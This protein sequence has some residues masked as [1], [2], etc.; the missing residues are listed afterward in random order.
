MQS[1]VMTEFARMTK[2]GAKK[3]EGPALRHVIDQWETRL[4]K[5]IACQGDYIEK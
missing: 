3:G 2:E 1:A 5:V 4:R